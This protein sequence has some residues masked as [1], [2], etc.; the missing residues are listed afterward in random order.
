MGRNQ[1]QKK[2]LGDSCDHFRLLQQRSALSLIIKDFAEYLTQYRNVPSEADAIATTRTACELLDRLLDWHSSLP[3]QF[4]VNAESTAPI[5]VHQSFYLSVLITLCSIEMPESAE[6]EDW[7]ERA[8]PRVWK[9]TLDL[10]NIFRIHEKLH[11]N[12]TAC[13][14]LVHSLSVALNVLLDRN[15]DGAYD[16]EIIDLCI[17]LKAMSRRFP[18]AFAVFRMIQI[19]ARESKKP[20][21]QAT[22]RLVE[23]FVESEWVNRRLVELESLYPV[24]SVNVVSSLPTPQN[25]TD[26]IALLDHLGID[27]VEHTILSASDGRVVEEATVLS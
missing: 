15:E 10:V 14:Y 11:G 12:A 13:V 1:S 17:F 25:M 24:D 20:L 4:H 9:A 8:R 6:R 16:A 26:F 27:D 23:D 18:F 7:L 5:L 2:D 3:I 19:S 22:K 21:P